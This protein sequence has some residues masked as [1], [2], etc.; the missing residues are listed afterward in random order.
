MAT[1]AREAWTDSRLDELVKRID[2]GFREQREEARSFRAE[3][4]VRL[5]SQSREFN[6]RFDRMQRLLS[7]ALLT[8][9]ASLAATLVSVTFGN[10]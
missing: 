7:V 8:F 2:D 6:E 3:V 5:E 4:N 9:M 10:A 1:M